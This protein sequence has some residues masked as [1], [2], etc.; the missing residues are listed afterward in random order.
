MVKST[1]GAPSASASEPTP[2]PALPSATC[3]PAVPPAP[4]PPSLC[5]FTSAQ[6]V[7]SATSIATHSSG[8]RVITISPSYIA[9]ALPDVEA[10]TRLVAQAAAR[11]ARHRDVR[12]LTASRGV[13]P[14]QD[15]EAARVIHH[16]VVERRV[17]DGVHPLDV[18][19]RERGGVDGDVLH[20][21]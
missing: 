8:D 2:T 7:P 16:D 13:R 11:C 20:Q 17:G 3:A 18:D 1:G 15:A 14:H 5:P 4:G 12:E 9:G 10:G 19:A 6:P 21:Q